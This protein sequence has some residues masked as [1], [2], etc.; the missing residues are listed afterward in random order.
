MLVKG[1]MITV[2][3]VV[4]S[5]TLKKMILLVLVC[6]LTSRPDNLAELLVEIVSSVLIF[7]YVFYAQEAYMN[8]VDTQKRRVK[9][10]REV[11][12]ALGYKYQY[13]KNSTML[14]NSIPFGVYI[15]NSKDIHIFNS[16]FQQKMELPPRN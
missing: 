2:F 8:K 12:L 9:E 16:V 7:G 14:I 11:S 10:L 5:Y 15:T 1:F 13:K 6:I 4:P 3:R